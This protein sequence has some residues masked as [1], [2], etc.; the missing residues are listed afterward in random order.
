[1]IVDYELV[2]GI[3]IGIEADEIYCVMDENDMPDFSKP[4]NPVIYVYLGFI[5]FAFMFE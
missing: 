3:K 4:P 1:M 5:A 2:A